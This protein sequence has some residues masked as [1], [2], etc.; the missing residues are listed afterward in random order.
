MK[1]FTPIPL[2]VIIDDDE[3]HT[4]ALEMLMQNHHFAEQIITFSDGK[5]ALNF[6]S[7]AP[8]SALQL[9]DIVLLDIEMPVI[10]AWEF[11]EEFKKIRDKFTQKKISIYILSNSI[12]EKDKDKASS[13]P[14]VMSY[15][16]KPL[17][18]EDLER[19]AKEIIDNTRVPA[20]SF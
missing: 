19:I 4:F 13:Y 17:K 16:V 12:Y 20:T 15:L 1:S 9:P 2:A 10:D 6:F 7:A 5:D 3:I 11:L 14:E 18:R 8:R